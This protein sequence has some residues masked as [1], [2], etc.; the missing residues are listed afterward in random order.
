MNNV[1][2]AVNSDK[3]SI[4]IPFYHGA[5]YIPN[6]ISQIEICAEYVSDTELELIFSN[7]APDEPLEDTITSQN[8]S[9][10][11]I[12]TTQNRGIHGARVRGLQS[13]TGDYILF[14]D[15]DDRIVPEYF[16]SQ[17][18]AI[19]S[20][21]AVICNALS[22]GRIKYNT[23][24]P[25]YK[26]ADR[27][28]MIGEGCMILSPGQ[29]LIRRTAIPQVWMENIMRHNGA[30]DWLLWLCMHSA[31]KQFA[32][33]DDVLFIRE[34]HYHN[35]SFDSLKMAES[36]REVV[37]II[38]SQALLYEEER[39]RLQELLPEIQ[40]KRIKETEKFK[41]M[42]FLQND[43]ML[44]IS[45]GKTVADY[46]KK[47]QI[48]SIALY[49]YG[50]LGRMLLKSLEKSDIEISY[51]IDKNADYLDTPVKCCTLEKKLIEVDAVIV[52]LV[53]DCR[54]MV[55]AQIRK[56]MKTE[57]FWLEDVIADISKC[58]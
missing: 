50:Y 32:I 31:G 9:I 1:K 43:W 54:K 41:K 18:K 11:V 2:F 10:K 5:K 34:I 17:L 7:D 51:V 15:Q 14:L 37:E 42:F 20:A 27:K 23:D 3:C 40:R 12:N 45:E 48:K 29:V 55:D 6:L 39:K 47:K 46:F 30:D 19:G 44:A 36:E 33:N 16:D 28:C 4:I 56:K 49:G 13:S 22:G 58:N 8:I 38:E 26:A 24:R 57:I 53:L 21:D 25:L 35:T 52:T